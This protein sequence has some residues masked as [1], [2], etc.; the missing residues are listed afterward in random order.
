MRAPPL[1]QEAAG[2]TRPQ[3]RLRP[4]DVG[5]TD[6]EY[7]LAVASLGRE[8][9][10]VE[11]GM[12]GALWS[13][14]C[15]YKH[16]RPL[17]RRLPSTAPHVVVGPGENAGAVDL[18]RGLACVFKIESH[19]HPSAVEPFQGAATGVGGIVRDIFTMG[20]RPVALLNALFFGDPSKSR[21]RYLAGGVVGGISSYGNCLGIPDVGGHVSFDAS[22]DDNPLVNA[23][24]V[25][26]APAGRITRATGAAPGEA[27]YLVGADTGRDGIAGASL[28][29]SFEL[30]RDDDAKRPSVQVGDPFLEKLVMEACLELAE[31]D[32]VAAMQDLGAAGLSC[33][34]SEV[35][36]KA[37]AGID[38]DVRLVPR[39]AAALSAYE[40]MLSESQERMLIVP[41]PGHESAVERIAA[42]WGLHCTRIGTVVADDVIRVRDGDAVAAQISAALLADGAPMYD[43]AGAPPPATE[44]TLPAGDAE[45][46]SRL[47]AFLGGASGSSRE[48]IYRR[49]DQMVGVDTVVGPGADAAVLRLKGRPD[50]IAMTVDANPELARSDPYLAA[51]ATVAEACRNL[52]CVGARALGLTDCINAGNP[53]RPYGAW[54]LTRT[55]EG[56]ADA[57][58]SL[59]VP[60]VS[61]NVSLYNASGGRDI[62]ATAVVGAVGKLDDVSKA[63]PPGLGD[64]G[65]ALIV[66]GG[67][68]LDLPRERRMH[69]LLLDAAAGGL[70]SAAHDVGEGGVAVAVAEMAIRARLGARLAAPAFDPFAR[71][72]GRVVVATREAVRLIERCARAAVPAAI[73]GEVAGDRLSIDGLLDVAVVDCEREFRSGLALALGLEP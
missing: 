2:G 27:V 72:L 35:A 53:D 1:R 6:H 36:A 50:G 41:R 38:L 69:E 28:L 13:E 37:S 43:L 67:D 62:L 44:R 46:W 45:A 19:N 21:T 47:R 14:H 63:I 65:D 32:H 52:A 31:G 3:T 7:G 24:C 51:A 59:G 61:G 5:L 48:R 49:Y 23:M 30:G 15:A 39:R 64:E 26:I 29:A 33:A 22:Y 8:P 68:D 16:S 12:L 56:L 57:A 73:I 18:G 20:A 11:L 55:I 9:S 10:D 17:L 34:V 71:S 60:F 42:R 58:H 4:A 66:L 70:I 54:Q 40:V 25:G